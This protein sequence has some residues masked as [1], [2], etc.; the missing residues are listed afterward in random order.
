[1]DKLIHDSWNVCECLTLNEMHI[2][3][4]SLIVCLINY[5][6]TNTL[7]TPPPEVKKTVL[8]IVHL[9]I[10]SSWKESSIYLRLRLKSLTYFKHQQI[11]FIWKQT[12]L[13]VL[14]FQFLVLIFFYMQVLCISTRNLQSPGHYI[15][16]F[17]WESTSKNL[18]RSQLD[19]GILIWILFNHCKT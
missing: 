16:W 19:I 8:Y 4:A 17:A 14:F 1:M 12:F 7:S 13:Y 6:L 11:S 18:S 5:N 9:I 10:F 3:L 2:Q 15:F